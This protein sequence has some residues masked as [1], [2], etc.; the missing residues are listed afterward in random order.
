[1]TG[2]HDATCPRD[3]LHGLLVAG[4]S[5]LMYA[6]IIKDE[7]CISVYK[8]GHYLKRKQSMGCHLHRR[9]SVFLSLASV[10]ALWASHAIF[11]YGKEDGVISPKSGS[12]QISRS[13]QVA[14]ILGTR[15]F[16]SSLPNTRNRA[17]ETS[18]TQA[19]Y[20]LRTQTCFR[21]SL[22]SAESDRR[23]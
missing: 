7:L 6:F 5:P 10:S 1:M 16:F 8:F 2:S 18:S 14:H 17:R 19:G 3:L 23:K 20:S 9:F 21:L 22:V 12:H 13:R 4:T 11:I 15:G